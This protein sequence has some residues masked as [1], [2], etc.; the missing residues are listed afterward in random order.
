MFL[1]SEESFKN[2]QCNSVVIHDFRKLCLILKKR[3]GEESVR[4]PGNYYSFLKLMYSKM[5]FP[6]QKRFCKP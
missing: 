5:A 3:L 1:D 6:L 4:N 2:I